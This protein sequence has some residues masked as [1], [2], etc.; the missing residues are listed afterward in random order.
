MTR[1]MHT[2]PAGM[3]LIELLVAV[4]AAALLMGLLNSVLSGVHTGVQRTTEST[5]MADAELAGIRFVT[6]AVSQALPPD[7]QNPQTSFQ[8]TPDRIEFLGMPPDAQARRGP[9]KIRLYVMPGKNDQRFLAAEFDW[10]GGTSAHR[11]TD[12][13]F[14]LG[15]VNSISFDYAGSR[16]ARWQNEQTWSEPSQLPELI[17]LTISFSNPRRTP[18]RL[19]IAPRRTISGRCHF[20]LVS[21][22]CRS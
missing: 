13:R 17:R 1:R 21:P 4:A 10:T 8:G 2:T 9:A 22:I 18:I 19:A 14:V 11:S 16:L 12:V 6:T 20:D 7:P 3:T 5:L 15:D